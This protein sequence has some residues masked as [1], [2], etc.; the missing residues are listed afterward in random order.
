MV[1]PEPTS[2]CSSRSMRLS[3]AMSCF[4]F[5]QRLQLRIGKRKGQG[6]DGFA[7]SAPRAGDA[8]GLWYRAAG[9]GSAAA[10]AGWPATRHRPGAGERGVVRRQIG[11]MRRRMGRS[12]APH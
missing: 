9:R 5:G 1:L 11:F 2:P 3:E 6:G 7:P 8:P 12:Q 10:P 4:D